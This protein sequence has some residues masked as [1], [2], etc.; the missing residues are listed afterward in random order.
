[1]QKI[2]PKRFYF[3]SITVF[4]ISSSICLL[5]FIKIRQ[6]HTNSYNNQIQTSGNLA[7]Q[8]FQKTVYNNI[9]SLE[10]LKFRIEESNGEFFNFLDNDSK[11][12]IA[13]NPAIKFI[14]WIDKNGIITRVVPK[15]ENKD[16]VGLDIK[17]LK[18]RYPDWLKFSQKDVINI[19]PWVKLTQ[20]G[21][22][23]LI[24]VPVFFNGEFQGTITS[25]MDFKVEFDKIS[26]KLNE[27]SILIKDEKGNVFYSFNDTIPANFPSHRI[28]TSRLV[29]D[30]AISDNWNFQFIYKDN[31]IYKERISVQ[32]MALFIGLVFSLLFSLLTYFFLIARHETHRLEVI[33][34]NLN[35]VNTELE[36]Q[37]EMANK[38]SLAKTQFL[39]N[40]SHEIRTPLNAIL[41][42]S[43][44]LRNKGLGKK[45]NLYLKL[46]HD[47]ANALLRLVNDIL[48]I[49]KIESGKTKV[50]YNAFSPKKIIKK[51]IEIYT[52]QAERKKIQLNFQNTISGKNKVL[53]DAIKFEQIFTNL[54][55]NAIKFTH[56]GAINVYYTEEIIDSKLVTTLIVEDTGIG[57]P[58]DKLDLV[59]NRFVQVEDGTRKQH[60]G[61]G[62]GLAITKSLVEILQGVISVKSHPQKGTKFTVNIPF[63]LTEDAKQKSIVVANYCKMN[64]LIVDDNRLNRLILANYLEEIGIKTKAVHGGEA[65]IKE[66]EKKHY[67]VIL[68]DIHMP[69]MDGFE[70]VQQIRKNGNTTI[71]IGVSADVTKEAIDKGF[72][73][74]MDE[75]LLKP[76]VKKELY[77]LLEKYFTEN[78]VDANSFLELINK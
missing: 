45:E 9:K 30:P 36:V 71:I 35:I 33:N 70:T 49:D 18:Y 32:N 7:A 15:E 29:P 20:G 24:D 8:D 69:E 2:I 41:G 3:I 68:M 64:A 53:G 26:K 52:P 28:F 65:A 11:R 77:R 78:K 31:E 22:A 59:F 21:N 47:S 14:E 13:Q 60:G 62:L 27:H 5:I 16:V 58:I 75:Y 10:N 44:I 55:S 61:G 66:L 51:V 1:M 48:D 37:K 63:N 67:D 43:N 40:M 19:T 34:R 17:L 76:I 56:K 12:I 72:E 39:S 25:G 54:L 73:S 38:A 6:N 4:L 23:F 42:F 50:I 74:G 57:I 46:L